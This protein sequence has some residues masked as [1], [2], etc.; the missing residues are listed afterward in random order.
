MEQPFIQ[1]ELKRL[2]EVYDD[3]YI[4][5]QR[6]GDELYE[7]PSDIKV[8]LSLIPR[9]NKIDFSTKIKTLLSIKF[10]RE[11]INV[12]C[13]IK[14]VKRATGVRLSALVT[15]NW[16][17]DFKSNHQGEKILFYSFWMDSSTLGASYAKTSNPGLKVVTRCHNFDLFGN[18][19]NDFYIPFQKEIA[20]NIDGVY[21][22]SGAGEQFILEKYPNAKC[23]TKIMGVPPVSKLNSESKDG[24]FRIVSCS[25]LIPRKRVDLLMEFITVIV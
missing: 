20:N 14:K 6:K 12:R 13:N 11:V 9:L 1:N 10:I 16:I 7:I 25:Y 4:V 8:E 2:N 19:E 17:D 15:K 18:V 24:V 23:Q 22:V 21:P 3:I 5:P